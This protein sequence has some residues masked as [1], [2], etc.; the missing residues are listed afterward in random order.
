MIK[1]FY[2]GEAS[3]ESM[4]V[5]AWC[6]LLAVTGFPA[7][8]YCVTIS[9]PSSF[10]LFFL[11]HVLLLSLLS[12]H[13]DSTKV[14]KVQVIQYRDHVGDT[15]PESAQVKLH[16]FSPCLDLFCLNDISRFI[17]PTTGYSTILETLANLG[18]PQPSSWGPSS[19]FGVAVKNDNSIVLSSQTS[20]F[21]GCV[22]ETEQMCECVRWGE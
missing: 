19:Y 6:C 7:H 11:L 22:W 10:L 2:F 9:L 14:T 1:G 17:D 21:I 3:P 20:F 4:I 18:V 8:I 13:V 12:L 16:R 5:F 15:I